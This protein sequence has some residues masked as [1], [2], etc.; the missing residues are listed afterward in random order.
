MSEPT[1]PIILRS[2]IVQ[3]TNCLAL[4]DGRLVKCDVL[5]ENGNIISAEHLFYVRRRRPD[6][7]VD[8]D[9]AIVAP[10]FIDL[11]VNGGWGVDFSSPD[12][13]DTATALN[14]VATGVLA[15]G[16]TAF[17]PTLVTS[18]PDVY[19]TVLPG[20]GPRLGGLHGAAVI[21]AHLEGP[22]INPVKRGAHAEQ[23][24]RPLCGANKQQQQQCEVGEEPWRHLVAVYG[25]DVSNVAMVTLAPELL[26]SDHV[27]H[28]LTARGVVVSI[29]HSDGTLADAERAYSAGATMMTHLFNA[30]TQFHHRDPGL[31]GLLT[32]MRVKPQTLYYGV[33]ADGIHTHP[34]ALRLAWH[35][36]PTS[37][38]LVTDAMSAAG[39]PPGIHRIGPQLVRVQ[40]DGRA[41]LDT[42]S[43]NTQQIATTDDQTPKQAPTLS[44]NKPHTLESVKVPN[45]PATTTNIPGGSQSP[46][47]DGVGGVGGT[48]AG[49]TVTMDACVRNLVAATGCSVAAALEAA[50][51]RPAE[52]LRLAPRRGTLQPSARADL[53]IL[54]PQL[55]VLATFIDGERVYVAPGYAGKLKPQPVV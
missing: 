37:L 13:H 19:H 45:H 53:V 34:A 5:V 2:H 15:H 11:Q 31:V 6:F 26:G 39:L 10:G 51:L 54:S 21:G 33:I 44:A 47:E 35:S 55:H 4:C 24:V 14:T 8:C 30:M 18:P 17:L 12:L 28:Q 48:L 16:V 32:S 49:S 43:G 20:L 42:S 38:C 25:D 29:G 3:F 41:L 23:H 36:S 50:S 27:I 46:A 9:G 22:F 1:E 7:R 52:V 40:E